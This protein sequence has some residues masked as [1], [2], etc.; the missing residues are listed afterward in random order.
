MINFVTFKNNAEK[1]VSHPVNLVTL[2]AKPTDNQDFN[3]R[4]AVFIFTVPQQTNERM[5]MQLCNNR[6][7]TL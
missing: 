4:I 5:R 3:N 1:C 7:T 6:V 2:A